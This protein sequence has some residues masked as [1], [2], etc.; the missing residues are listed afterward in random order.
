MSVCVRA[1]ECVRGC[2]CRCTRA[3]V[4]VCVFVCF[5]VCECLCA[6]ACDTLI[7][8]TVLGLRVLRMRDMKRN[9]K[10]LLEDVI[11]IGP[12]GWIAC[13]TAPQVSIRTFVLVKQVK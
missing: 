1:R 10:N 12:L 5:R 6:C 7:E 9:K 4:C 11:V 8:Q 2:V 3:C 13:H